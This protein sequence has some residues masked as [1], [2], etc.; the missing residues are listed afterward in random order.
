MVAFPSPKMIKTNGI[1]MAVYEAG[2]KDGIPVV[3][4]HGF[5]ELAYSWR[6][7][8]PALASAGYHV[9]APDQRGY[10]GSS[11]PVAVDDYN[12]VALCGDLVG[13]LDEFDVERAVFIGHD[14]GASVVW[15]SGLLHPDRVDGVVGLSVPPV[16]RPRT[17]PTQAFR[18]IF[19]D[20][21]FYMLYFQEA[22]A[23]ADLE[24]APAATMRRMLGLRP[25]DPGAAAT[26]MLQ[27]GPEGY[28]ERLPEP[29]GLP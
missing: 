20:N 6:H 29:D 2:P 27:P 7:Q 19:G 10:G 1:D 12:I 13:L 21:F 5:P 24:R 18:R 17:P 26:R 23:D 25:P 22:A 15:G 3:L 8:I 28:V 16:P 9:L 14:W 4:C 11:R